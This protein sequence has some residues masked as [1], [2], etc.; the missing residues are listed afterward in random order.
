MFAFGFVF[1]VFAGGTLKKLNV[2]GSSQR[3]Q[4][5]GDESEDDVAQCEWVK[6]A[7]LAQVRRSEG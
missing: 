3:G 6:E 7:H 1:V 4:R 5:K 2:V